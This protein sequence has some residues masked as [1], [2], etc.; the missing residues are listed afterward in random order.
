[1]KFIVCTINKRVYDNL[2]ELK[3]DYS[4]AFNE[5]FDHL[6]NQPYESIP[7][8]YFKLVQYRAWEYKLPAF[9]RIYCKI[10]LADREKRVV[11][12]HAG[13][14]PNEGVPQPPGDESIEWTHV[15][16]L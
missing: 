15:Y 6:T 10:Y 9:H 3:E 8:K 1:M 12:Y 14:H 2:L 11:I 7:R 5:M 4:T 16:F 13:C